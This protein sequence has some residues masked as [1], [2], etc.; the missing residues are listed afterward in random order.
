MYP[1]SP[2][3][4]SI[5]RHPDLLALRADSEGAAVRP[6]AQIAES[7]S[8]LA[9]LYLAISPWVVGF[10]ASASALSVTDLVI[11]L[12]LVLLA[13]GYAPAFERTHGMAVAAL[14]IGAWAVIAPRVVYATPAETRAEVSNV[15]AGGVAVVLALLT[16]A[17]G[18]WRGR[19]ESAT[20]R[21]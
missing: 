2:R 9:G 13:L 11:G 12:T 4:A 6:G 20:R 7:L 17:L 15:V 3:T 18:A 19:A 21:T 8:L 5:E 1:Q 14:L 10:H 16:L